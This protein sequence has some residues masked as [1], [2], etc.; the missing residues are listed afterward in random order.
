VGLGEGVYSKP[1]GN[2]L[3]RLRGPLLFRLKETVSHS[4]KLE[5][6]LNGK[7]MG[8][9]DNEYERLGRCNLPY[10]TFTISTRT[11]RSFT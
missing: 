3:A 7:G 2:A 4:N 10:S 8:T 9:E 11:D 1:R 6:Y 5:A